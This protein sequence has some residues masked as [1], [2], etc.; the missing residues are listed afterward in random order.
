MVYTPLEVKPSLSS[1]VQLF[2]SDFVRKKIINK[3]QIHQL[4]RVDKLYWV[5]LLDLNGDT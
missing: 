2:A 5:I 3:A 1:R 4:T